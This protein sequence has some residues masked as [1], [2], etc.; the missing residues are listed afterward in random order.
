MSESGPRPPKTYDAFVREFPKLGQAWDAM[1]EA[2]ESGPFSEREQRL[3]KLAVA[4][5]S[6]HPG[7]VHSSVRKAR[8]AGCSGAEIRHVV[9][10]AASTIGLPP[11]VAA[12][13]WVVEELEKGGS[14]HSVEN[15]P[16]KP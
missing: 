4:I 10:L 7:P 1:R 14:S 13:S 2:E 3:L 11:A 8:A 5:G 6:G 12:Y 16:R 9:A 15:A